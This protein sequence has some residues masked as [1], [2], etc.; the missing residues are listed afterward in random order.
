MG[1]NR[2]VKIMLYQEEYYNIDSRRRQERED[3][4]MIQED[5]SSMSNLSPKVINKSFDGWK[6]VERLSMNDF[7]RGQGH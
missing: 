2:E 4:R 5:H 7:G 6:Y 3:G 1:R